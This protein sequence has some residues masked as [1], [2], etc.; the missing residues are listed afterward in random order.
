VKADVT[1]RLDVDKS[2]SARCRQTVTWR[3]IPPAASAARPSSPT[4]VPSSSVK[5]IGSKFTGSARA[6]SWIVRSA[7][8]AASTPSAPSKRPQLGTESR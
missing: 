6:A 5:S 4:G 7:S 3:P 8:S 1:G 2:P